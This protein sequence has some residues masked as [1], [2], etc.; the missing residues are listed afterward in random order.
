MRAIKR[1]E[2]PQ[3]VTGYA[4]FKN[5]RFASPVFGDITTATFF[6]EKDDEIVQ[7]I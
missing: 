3:N 5:G 1:S 2:H 6:A 4:A 7:L